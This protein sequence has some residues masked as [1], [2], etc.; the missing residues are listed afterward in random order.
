MVQ[1]LTTDGFKT[2]YRTLY[3]KHTYKEGEKQKQTAGL[4]EEF[5]LFSSEVN[6]KLQSATS[7]LVAVRNMFTEFNK[8]NKR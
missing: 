1:A 2:E 4:L 6:Q 7:E 5:K 3:G 8:K